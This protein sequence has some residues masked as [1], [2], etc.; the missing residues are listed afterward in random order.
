MLV[1]SLF[2]ALAACGLK[3]AL[4]C[5]SFILCTACKVQFPCVIK[6][7]MRGYQIW[8]DEIIIAPLVISIYSKQNKT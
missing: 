8:H 5:S 6:V 3:L 4:I 1:T 7:C 2:L